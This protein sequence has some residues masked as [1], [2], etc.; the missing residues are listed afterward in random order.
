MSQSRIAHFIANKFAAVSDG[1]QTHD[2][3]VR[4]V[5]G[6]LG[7]L[8]WALRWTTLAYVAVLFLHFLL[9][10]WVGERNVF[11]AFCLYLPPAD[12]K[13]VV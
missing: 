1:M 9:M 7:L 4:L 6:C 13:S 12:R 8:R 11:F 3:R 5:S 2:G 10:R